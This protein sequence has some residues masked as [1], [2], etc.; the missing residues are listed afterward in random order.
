MPGNHLIA[1][2]GNNSNKGNV[3]KQL[4]GAVTLKH[5]GFFH[6]GLRITTAVTHYIHVTCFL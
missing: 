2:Q 1:T 5:R 4:K 6:G 3:L